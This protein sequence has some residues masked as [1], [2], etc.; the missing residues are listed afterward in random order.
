M[1][2]YDVDSSEVWRSEYEDGGLSC[3]A[4]GEHHGVPER[5][6]YDHLRALGVDTGARRSERRIDRAALQAAH[7]AGRTPKELAA[8]FK[9]SVGVIYNT[10]QA[11]RRANSG[12]STQTA[13]PV[14][15][16]PNGGER[17]AERY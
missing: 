10:L 11:A 15:E 9:T 17:L 14:G 13:D 5:A 2:S 6:V 16:E 4:I 1:N 7:A 3:R 12:E 8:D